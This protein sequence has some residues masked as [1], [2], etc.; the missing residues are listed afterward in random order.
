MTRVCRVL[1]AGCRMMRGTGR[2]SEEWKAKYLELLE[3]AEQ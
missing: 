1:V 3:L 2:A